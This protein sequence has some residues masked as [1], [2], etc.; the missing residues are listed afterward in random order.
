MSV[1]CKLQVNLILQGSCLLIRLPASM[2]FVLIGE[3]CQNKQKEIISFY[4]SVLR[5]VTP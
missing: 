3:L 1:A 5:S 4:K 2:M